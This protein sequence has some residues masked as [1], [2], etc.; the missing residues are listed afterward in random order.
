MVLVKE[1]VDSMA[2]AGRPKDVLRK[3]PPMI[4]G[5]AIWAVS[6]DGMPSYW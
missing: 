1:T 2:L 5:T 6:P 3:V 4:G